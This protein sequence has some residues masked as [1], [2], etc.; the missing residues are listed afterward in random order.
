MQD[1]S[2]Q[3]DQILRLPDFQELIGLKRS[4]IYD[5]LD[6]KSPRHD[7]SFPKPIRLGLRA[8]GFSRHEAEQWIL[9]RIAAR[10]GA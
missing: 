5:R 3:P 2:Q 4:S 10:D 9:A 8:I 6:P 1:N 7:P